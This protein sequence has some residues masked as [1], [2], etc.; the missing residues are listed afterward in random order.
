MKIEKIKLLRDLVIVKRLPPETSKHIILTDDLIDQKNIGVV[1]ACGPGKVSKKG[2]LKKM[3]VKPGDTIAFE[4]M[5]FTDIDY[6]G[7]ACV[8]LREE[9]VLGV[10]E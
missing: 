6:N 5:S 3:S 10:L 7:E 1:V 2:N 4:R 8:M 9:K